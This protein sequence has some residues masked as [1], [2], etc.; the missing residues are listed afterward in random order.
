MW[1]SFWNF[2]ESAGKCEYEAC[3]TV[4]LDP[5]YLWT[6]WT[7][8]CFGE[9]AAECDYAANFTDVGIYSLRVIIGTYLFKPAEV[10]IETLPT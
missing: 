8:A 1:G 9:S 10:Y 5:N 7:L 4:G 2:G 6:F 3:W